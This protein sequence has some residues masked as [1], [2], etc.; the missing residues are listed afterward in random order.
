MLDI[1]PAVRDLAG[2]ELDEFNDYKNLVIWQI[3]MIQ[4]GGD[5][6]SIDNT[7]SEMLLEITENGSSRASLQARAMLEYGKGYHFEKCLP[8]AE[9]A[10][11]KSSEVNKVVFENGISISANPNPANSWVAF[12]Y[13]LPFNVNNGEILVT[14]MHGRIIVSFMVAG[15]SGQ[16]VWD[17]RQ[18]E[19]GIYVYTL[20]AGNASKQGKLVVQ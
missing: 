14:D 16:Q 20:K 10:S 1:I 13:E 6:T 18:L 9:Q 19:K 8:E 17:T 2:S 4:Q 11:L 5:I 3:Q 12:E 7:A 15:T